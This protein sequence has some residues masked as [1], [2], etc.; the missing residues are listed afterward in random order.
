MTAKT[1]PKAAARPKRTKVRAVQPLFHDNVYRVEDE[2]FWYVGEPLP[3]E[4]IVVVEDPSTPEGP[5]PPVPVDPAGRPVPMV[6][7][8]FTTRGFVE[9][10]HRR[11]GAESAS[12]GEPAA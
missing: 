7:P 8:T 9:A 1:T 5:P 2:V 12:D 6:P 10:A 11:A 4:E 3:S